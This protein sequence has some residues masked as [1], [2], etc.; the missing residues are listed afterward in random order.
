MQ[1][2][3]LARRYAFAVTYARPRPLSWRRTCLNSLQSQYTTRVV[4]PAA[5]PSVAYNLR[6]LDPLRVTPHDYVDLSDVHCKLYDV[7][8]IAPASSSP[9]SSEK[10]LNEIIE[11]TLEPPASS[12]PEP[13]EK[14]LNELIQN[15]IKQP[16]VSPASLLSPVTLSYARVV[17]R[18]D[19]QT[20]VQEIRHLPF[21]SNT[22]GFLY[23]HTP[24][25]APPTAGE[26]RFHLVRRNDAGRPQKGYDLL[27]N[28]GIPWSYPLL[29]IAMESSPFLRN[30]LLRDGLVTEDVLTLCH[31]LC[32]RAAGRTFARWSPLIYQLNQPFYVDLS[33]RNVVSWLLDEAFLGSFKP[34]L[35][36]SDTR[37]DYKGV[38]PYT[39]SLLCHFESIQRVEPPNI[40]LRI[41][42]VLEDVRCM[43]PNY[44]GYVC[45][46][47]EGEFLKLIVRCS[48]C[49]AFVDFFIS[50]K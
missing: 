12:P 38:V 42:K 48:A 1:V 36:F 8:Q 18:K 22:H 34:R 43:I 19:G 39:G 25:D 30:I 14:P 29:A 20:G 37:A 17:V 3:Y 5:E 28:H 23:Y 4:A 47:A 15:I 26:L 10:A 21:P 44:D 13:P 40:A 27:N 45:M 49:S 46:P 31:R 2:V 6:T 33:D 11:M 50:K 16:A 41:V 35:L 24:P 7:N 9:E 32:R